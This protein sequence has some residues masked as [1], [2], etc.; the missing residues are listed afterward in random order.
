MRE[1]MAGMRV[2][3]SPA[4]LFSDRDFTAGE[5]HAQWVHRLEGEAQVLMHRSVWA[6]C[7]LLCFWEVERGVD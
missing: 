3:L 7:Q 4:L 5:L 2:G 1:A 6:C